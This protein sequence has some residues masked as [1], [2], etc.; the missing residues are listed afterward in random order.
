MTFETKISIEI[1]GIRRSIPVEIKYRVEMVQGKPTPIHL[2]ATAVC[3]G[4]RSSG[5][6]I[7]DAMGVRQ[8]KEL[9]SQLI[10]NWESQKGKAA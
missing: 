2:S 4:K 9:D 5:E 6:W 3:W 8:H 10:E 1:A 7:Y